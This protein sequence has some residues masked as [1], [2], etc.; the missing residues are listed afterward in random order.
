M[1]LT[2]QCSHRNFLITGMAFH[3]TSSS[4]FKILSNLHSEYGWLVGCSGS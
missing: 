3:L 4:A 1:D 2:V